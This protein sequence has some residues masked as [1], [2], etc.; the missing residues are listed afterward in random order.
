MKHQVIPLHRGLSP[1]F[2][3]WR[4]LAHHAH[5]GSLTEQEVRGFQR[6][7][8]LSSG[9]AY[10]ELP[11]GSPRYR[12]NYPRSG[13]RLPNRRPKNGSSGLLRHFVQ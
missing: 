5:S 4:R 9:H 1:N 11:T 2:N 7:A 13:G 6:F 10:H 8:D 3:R 12:T